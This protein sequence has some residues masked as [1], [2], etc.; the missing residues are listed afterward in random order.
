MLLLYI[1]ITYD[2]LFDQHPHHPNVVHVFPDTSKVAVS[3]VHRIL[4]RFHQ[5]YQHRQHGHHGHHD[6]RHQHHHFQD[7]YQQHPL[8]QIR[9]FSRL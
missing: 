3:C 2:D 4:V 9:G 6:H 5:A 1:Y 7:C 8:H